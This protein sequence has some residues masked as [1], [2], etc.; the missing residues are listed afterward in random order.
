MRGSL[1]TDDLWKEERPAIEQ[2]V[3]QDLSNPQYVFYTQMLEAMFQGTPYAHDALG[4]RPSFDKTTGQMLHQFFD[5]WYAPNN[6]IF[7][8]AGDVE[9]EHVLAEVKTLFGD[10]PKKSLPHGPKS[11][12]NGE[13]AR[14]WRYPRIFLTGWRWFPS[15][16]RGRTVR[17]LPPPNCSL[18]CSAA[19]A[20]LCTPWCRKGRRFTRVFS[21][22][23]CR[24]QA[25][26]TLWRLPQGG[27]GDELVSE[28]KKMLCR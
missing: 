5:T 11:I 16:C 24:R 19:S 3:A 17:I 18:T 13:G 14:R 26:A 8:I 4:S 20:A 2:E 7:V 10:I 21:S 15:G 25:W 12:L 27:N 9:P 28:I 23:P 22:R 1:D 6:A